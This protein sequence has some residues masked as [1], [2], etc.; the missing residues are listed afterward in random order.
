MDG[1]GDQKLLRRAGSPVY[2]LA[3][4]IHHEGDAVSSYFTRILK[5]V[6]ATCGKHIIT[7]GIRVNFRYITGYL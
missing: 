1:R 4:T 5:E 3:N 7:P 6:G 2:S